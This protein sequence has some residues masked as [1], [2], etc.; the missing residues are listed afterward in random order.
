MSILESGNG[1]AFW[2]CTI[3]TPLPP[4]AGLP[5]FGV[6]AW[7]VSDALGVEVVFGDTATFV[8]SSGGCAWVLVTIVR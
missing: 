5:N 8:A 7:A 4:F 6:S 2:Q 3:V 1:K